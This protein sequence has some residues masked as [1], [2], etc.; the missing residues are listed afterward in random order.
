MD[1]LTE[2][3]LNIDLGYVNRIREAARVGYEAFLEAAGSDVHA[4]WVDG[5]VIFLSPVSLRH[6]RINRFLSSLVD[7][8]LDTNP[9]GE[10]FYDS[11]QMKTGPKLGGRQPDLI[12]VNQS[13]NNRLRTTYIDGP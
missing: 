12:F 8:Y 9:I 10:I 7:R 5:E 11:V 6:S 2:D 1:V 4:E 13:N 3:L